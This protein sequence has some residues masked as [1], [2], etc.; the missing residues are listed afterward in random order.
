VITDIGSLLAGFVPMLWFTLNF[1]VSLSG[2]HM[3]DGHIA[4][5]SLIK[6]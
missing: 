3:A 1:G 6:T 5:I 4:E 2:V